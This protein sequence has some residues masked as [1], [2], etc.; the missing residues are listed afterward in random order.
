MSRIHRVTFVVLAVITV[1]AYVPGLSGALLFDSLPVLTYNDLAK[2]DPI[3][4]DNWRIA[5]L[6]FGEGTR[7]ISMLSFA[8]QYGFAGEWVAWQLKLGNL[9]IHLVTG[10]L[11]FQLCRHVL[12][13]PSIQ[14]HSSPSMATWISLLAAGLWLLHPLFVSTVVYAVQRMAQLSTLFIVLGLLVFVRY[15]NTW[16][17]KVPRFGQVVALGLWVLLITILGYLSKENGVMLLWLLP[18]VELSFYRGVIAGRELSWLKMLTWLALVAPLVLLGFMYWLNPDWFLEAYIHRDFTLVERLLTQSRVLWRYII[19]T[20]VPNVSWMGLH[21]DDIAISHGLWQPLTTFFAIVAWLLAVSIAIWQRNRWPL[22]L[23]AVLFYLV[24]HVMESSIIGL[25]LVYEHRNYLPLMGLFILIAYGVGR[26]SVSLSAWKKFAPGVGLIVLCALLTAARS[27]TWSD[28]LVMGAVSAENHP[29]SQR[30]Q[31]HY[32]SA[33]LNELNSFEKGEKVPSI[34]V[35]SARDRLERV[36]KIN[37]KSLVAPITMLLTDHQLPLKDLDY[38]LWKRR[39]FEAVEVTT[40]TSEERNGLRRLAVCVAINECRLEYREML[41]LLSR[42]EKRFPNSPHIPHA[43]AE[44][45]AL[46]GSERREE[47]VNQARK[48]WLT[49]PAYPVF[50]YTLI[51][52]LVARGELGEASEVINSFYAHDRKRRELSRIKALFKDDTK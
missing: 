35:D 13:A 50:A 18:V 6:S 24:A 49:H 38:N 44:L 25:E 11:L 30:S 29:D 40:A 52:L 46:L 20:V 41:S 36:A 33:L 27:A 47:A 4:A 22:F 3:S 9:L 8:F 31:F 10:Y 39:L 21:H 34:I 14:R 26:L 28:G 15:R 12:K 48:A 45:L 32:A 7:A 42:L 17:D 5:A 2:L 19:W 1:V 37:P 16:V 23:F 43:K 51:D